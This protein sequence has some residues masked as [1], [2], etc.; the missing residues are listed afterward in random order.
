[1]TFTSHPTTFSIL[2]LGKREAPAWPIPL[3]I[4][5]SIDGV[6][7]PVQLAGLYSSFEPRIH[8]NVCLFDHCVIPRHVSSTGFP[9]F[10][11]SLNMPIFELLTQVIPLYRWQ[12]WVEGCQPP[13]SDNL[14]THA[15]CCMLRWR[16]AVLVPT[17]TMTVT[18]IM[19]CWHLGVE[20]P[21]QDL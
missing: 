5:H 11:Y 8:L 13:Q 14:I 6:I 10:V 3:Y 2:E 12:G 1:M 16:A 20:P 19:G 18:T 9:D 15:R 17:P 21:D 4:R 7:C